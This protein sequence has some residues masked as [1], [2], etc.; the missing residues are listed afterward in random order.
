MRYDARLWPDDRLRNYGS[1][2]RDGYLYPN[3]LLRAD[4]LDVAAAVAAFPVQ[5][6]GLRAFFG[7]LVRDL[8]LVATADA[9]A[10]DRLTV[11]KNGVNYAAY[12]VDTGDALASPVRISTETGTKAVRLKT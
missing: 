3:S 8:C 2:R 5:F 12:L 7:G 9:P 1:P 10:G 11:N 4:R 6:F